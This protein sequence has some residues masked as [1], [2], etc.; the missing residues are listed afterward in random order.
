MRL[1]HP[2]GASKRRV[3]REEVPMITE[4]MLEL[5]DARRG[6]Y[7]S[8]Q[9]V[10]DSLGVTR[11]SVWKAV[12]E[13][14]E[15]GYYI[16]AATRRGYRFAPENDV[17]SAAGVRAHLG[18]AASGMAVEVFDSVSSTNTLL[19]ER[20]AAG[21]AEGTVLL[22]SR[23]TAGRGR[24]G[25]EFYSPAAT[26]L[27][28]SVLLRPAIAPGLAARIT[29]AA[30]VAMC[31]AIER[32]THSR[33]QIKWVNDVFVGGRKV[34]GILTEAALGM[35]SGV[36]EYA[37]LG[38]GVNVYRPAGG[39]PPDIAGIAGALLDAPCGN[40]RAELAGVFLTELGGLYPQLETGAFMEE[41]RRR[42][43]VIGRRVSV[44]KR[45]GAL[46]ATALDID[47]DCHLRVRY[48]DGQEETLS[49][50]EI[51]ISLPAVE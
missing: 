26:G 36:L 6:E 42:S 35:E 40:V 34:C 33:P 17:L 37:V 13:L 46:E 19:R 7:L 4:R 44:R 31:R 24:F 2:G 47:A 30:A 41:Y 27:Y 39:F 9:S 45:E 28:M 48:D 22:A 11:A 20:A 18:A 1:P 15:S 43:L 29:T 21:A 3:L 50:G 25:R 14:Q 32:C 38:A 12:K 49:S 16:D 8:G 51:S 10:A 23:Q 5:F